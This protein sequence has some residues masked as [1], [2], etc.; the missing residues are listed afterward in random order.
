MAQRA[1]S[2]S[3]WTQAVTGIGFREP[4]GTAVLAATVALAIA[5]GASWSSRTQV[6][7]TLSI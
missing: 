1:T 5:G 6:A 4:P 3:S 2:L 7:D